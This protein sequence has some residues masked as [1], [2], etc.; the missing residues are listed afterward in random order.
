MYVLYYVGTR[1]LPSIFKGRYRF[2]G[3]M[4]GINLALIR[5]A[6]HWYPTQLFDNTTLIVGQENLLA[7]RLETLHMIPMI[8]IKAFCY[9]Y[10]SATVGIAKHINPLPLN[11]TKGSSVDNRENLDLYHPE[12]LADSNRTTK[13]LREWNG[14][15]VPAKPSPLQYLNGLTTR[16]QERSYFIRTPNART[17]SPFT[18]QQMS[19]SV[20]TTGSVYEAHQISI[21]IYPYLPVQKP[22][23]MHHIPQKY[24]Y[25]TSS[26][27][28]RND[29]IYLERNKRRNTCLTVAIVTSDPITNPSAGDLYT[30]EEL[31]NSLI[32][33]FP[34]SIAEI[35]YL[36]RYIHWYD[37]ESLKDIDMLISL[38][39]AFDVS[40]ALSARPPA[41][42][43][44][45]RGSDEFPELKPTLITIAWPRNWFQRWIGRPFIGNFDMIL[46]S[47]ELSKVF[48]DD[49][50]SKFGFQTRCVMGCTPL[51]VHSVRVSRGNSGKAGLH[52]RDSQPSLQSIH[53]TSS[54]PIARGAAPS[55]PKAHTTSS[56]HTNITSTSTPGTG[57]DMEYD[58]MPRQSSGVRLSV[59]I[60]LM[61]LATSPSRFSLTSSSSSVTS[62]TGGT[63]RKIG[64]SPV[65]TADYAFTGSYHNVTRKIT[66]FDPASLP[67]YKGLIVGSNWDISNAS[68]AWLKISI[69]SL[70]YT[71]MPDV[72]RAVKI[73]IDDANYVTEPWG[74]VNSRV[75]DALSAG[76]L[77][78]TNGHIGASEICGGEIPVFHNATELRVLLA[79][80]L[81]HTA[82]RLA[83]VRR[84]RGQILSHHTYDHRADELAG[85]LS[86]HFGVNLKKTAVNKRGKGVFIRAVPPPP[87]PTTNNSSATTMTT[88][89]ATTTAS[90]RN[91]TRPSMRPVSSPN[92]TTTSRINSTAY[93]TIKPSTTTRPT[94]RLTSKPTAVPT[95]V[96]TNAPTSKPVDHSTICIAIRTYEKQVRWLDLLVKSLLSQ[97]AE[98][99]YS[100]QIALKLFIIDTESTSNSFQ[101]E[102]RIMTDR[103]LH[104][105]RAYNSRIYFITDQLTT[106]LSRRKN[107]FYGYDTTDMLISYIIDNNDIHTCDWLMLTNGDNMYN[108][109]WLDTITP[110]ILHNNTN[111]IAW[112]FVSH[113]RR[114]NGTEQVIHVNMIRKYIDLGSM[115][116][117][118]SLYM[119]NNIKFLS[120]SLFTSDL[121][122]RDYYVINKIY[123]SIHNNT[124]QLLHNVLMFH[125]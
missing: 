119:N 51:P 78:I 117:R 77:V 103:H 99:K 106:D 25:L 24:D 45:K 96:L 20:T 120:E 41:V 118:M 101:N 85:Y 47:S 107:A 125:Q 90:V 58:L 6:A 52:P 82:E 56:A 105:F 68:A 84:L 28:G 16:T 64:A 55:L 7:Q 54:S 35:R 122:A 57:N 91:V 22:S 71:R 3:F 18:S 72:Y 10:K 15:R 2:N 5:P 33:L 86:T 104:L 102:V 100:K 48:F 39:D 79:H 111:I 31:G 123:N 37:Y 46:V 42:I 92:I 14:S 98:S 89:A 113:H 95:A 66:D 80:Y 63:G 116:T 83:L 114:G 4:F 30:A 67:A 19:T 94:I 40:K 74:S 124:V 121:F 8:S 50:S 110:I 73:V 21:D 12:N 44:N 34:T 65:L 23:H 93:P 53:R 61:R 112:D 36:R 69:G 9:H 76:A 43:H 26:G 75:F 29:C 108:S 97:H 115:I 38:L 49:Y 81:S 60:E 1:V 62:S 59:P 87:T 11:H 13:R 32:S 27:V 109:I 70:P 88:A 17:T